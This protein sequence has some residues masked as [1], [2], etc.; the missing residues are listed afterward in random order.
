MMGGD[1]VAGTVSS[2]ACEWK[3]PKGRY[4][5][6]IDQITGGYSSGTR[7]TVLAV[8][9]AA[10]CLVVLFWLDGNYDDSILVLAVCYSFAV[11]GMVVQIGHG[12]QL[13]FHQSVFM[14]LG[15]Y[16]VGV[17]NTRYQVP[18]ILAIL[19]M[20]AGSAVVGGIIGS[21]ATRVPGFALALATLFFA[22]IAS[23][24][25]GYSSYLGQATGIVG[26]GSIWSGPDYVSTLERSAAVAVLLLGA[27][28]FA[29]ARI[30]RSAIGLELSLI[31]ENEHMAASLGINTHRRKL[32]VFVLSAALAALGGGVF[33]GTQT[34]V[35][36]GN[37]DQTAELTLLIML[38]IGG[39][40]TIVG[41]LVGSLLIEY[42]QE[43]NTFISSHVLIIEGVL[44]TIVLLY[45]PEGLMGVIRRGAEKIRV[46]GTRRA[47]LGAGAVGPVP[48]PAVAGDGRAR[49][50]AVAGALAP[51]SRE[52]SSM[53]PVPPLRAPATV[54]EGLEIGSAPRDEEIALECM[55]VTKRF[56]GVVA[57]DEV[58]LRVRG[59]GIHALCGPNGAGKTTL[60][61]IICGGLRADRGTLYIRGQDVTRVPAY[62]RAQLG[63]ARTLQAVRLMGSRSVL[64]NVAVA[65]VSSHRTFITHALLKSDLTAAY[66]RA[67]E[68]L[69]DL[70]LDGVAGQRAGELTL[71]GQR[72]TELARAIVTGPR[73]LLLDEPASGLSSEQR[74]RLAEFLTQLGERMTVVLV[75]HDLQMVMEISK[76]IFVLL[77]GSLV[78][79]GDAEA[80]KAS[81]LIRT[82]LMGLMANEALETASD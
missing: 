20:V 41:G 11:I 72:M 8:A 47:I 5:R 2:A 57:V 53:A 18:V 44:F 19:A 55:G 65:A 42:L 51:V 61:E 14:M 78:F 25:V 79:T 59:L 49:S 67:W 76:E 74:G 48:V 3:T 9:V 81:E 4:A 31:S 29:C 35:S 17:L 52:A 10:I 62:L 80:F 39:R 37:F 56:G 13:A 34:L 15:G 32:E 50:N 66:E 21:V 40:A 75:E 27:C 45:A 64:D 36:P 30:M 63:V 26:I 23:D 24:Y 28:V 70:G 68:T 71:E 58:S 6:T 77:D 73:I 22:V 16:G 60:F 43:G 12:G 69:R 82:A 7:S 1:K 54:R 33:A 46:L 38:F